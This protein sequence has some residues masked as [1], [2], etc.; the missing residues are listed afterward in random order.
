MAYLLSGEAGHNFNCNDCSIDESRKSVWGCEG[1][2]QMSAPTM[3]DIDNN[4]VI[5]YWSCPVKFVP[6]SVW[7]FVKI[8]NYYNNHPSAPFP[9]FNNVSPRWLQAEN[10]LNAEMNNYIKEHRKKSQ[11]TG[12]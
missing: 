11:T 12:N 8:R 3:I 5:K 7:S 9:S 2:C 4:I 1:R 10:I 6:S